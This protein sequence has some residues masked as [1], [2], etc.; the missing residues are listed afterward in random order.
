MNTNLI[1]RQKKQKRQPTA[2][3]MREQL[4]IAADRIIELEDRIYWIRHLMGWDMPPHAEA[5]VPWWR[6]LFR[7][8]NRSGWPT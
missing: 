2:K 3:V 8:L 4:A 1:P 5:T 7:K 6:R